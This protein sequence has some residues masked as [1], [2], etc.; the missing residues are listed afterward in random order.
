[1][2][3]GFLQRLV[4][5]LSLRYINEQTDLKVFCDTTHHGPG[6]GLLKQITLNNYF[7][8]NAFFF[9]I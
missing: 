7:L 3:L 4:L 8:K 2:R 6:S 5:K 9:Y 1:M